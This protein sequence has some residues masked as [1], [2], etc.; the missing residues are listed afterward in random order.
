MPAQECISSQNI[1]VRLEEVF[2]TDQFLQRRRQL[3]FLQLLNNPSLQIGGNV[4]QLL[5]SK[6]K[7]RKLEVLWKDFCKPV[8]A[9]CDDSCEVVIESDEH[10]ID[11]SYDVGPCFSI[12]PYGLCTSD[13]DCGTEVNSGRRLG[14]SMLDAIARK[15][16]DADLAIVMDQ[17][18]PYIIGKIDGAASAPN[19]SG[20]PVTVNAGCVE[21]KSTQIT[22]GSLYTIV[23]NLIS[24]NNITNPMLIVG[25]QSLEN[26]MTI[27]E[28]QG[29]ATL[30]TRLLGSI[31]HFFDYDNIT[32]ST[33]GEAIYI[34]NLDAWAA[35]SW[36]EATQNIDNQSTESLLNSPYHKRW[37]RWND[38][39]MFSDFIKI[40]RYQRIDCKTDDSEVVAR[41]MKAH[42]ELICAPDG[43]CNQYPKVIKMKCA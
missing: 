12:K 9:D 17:I 36:N 39:S 27:A 22:G 28:A 5:D 43:V 13:Y 3:E 34:I 16:I 20:I 26:A 33:G 18:I 1:K 24:R 2:G 30:L 7:C 4:T 40:D 37:L 31:P 14:P 6:G 25:N 29:E 35:L 41:K 8:E 10:C 42:F 21:L 32:G 11:E 23:K 15:D 38:E 19:I